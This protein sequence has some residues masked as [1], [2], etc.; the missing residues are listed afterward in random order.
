MVPD[1]IT[2]EESLRQALNLQ[3][4]Y[5]WLSAA[6]VY[7]RVLK[8][9]PAEAPLTRAD[10]LEKQAY[11]LHKAAMQADTLDAFRDLNKKSAEFYQKTKEAAGVPGSPVGQ[12]TGIR[13][14][15]MMAMI[16][17]W[18]AETASDKKLHVDDAWKLA[19]EALDA[20]ESV[21]AR[22]Q[23]AWTFNS[24]ALS[25]A[26]SYNY[27]DTA[28]VREGRLREALNYAEKAI[29]HLAD[30]SDPVGLARAHAKTTCI[31]QGIQKDFTEFSQKDSV[32][33]ES[34]NHW[35]KA[36]DASE[37][38]ALSE[39]I[40][41]VILQGWPSACSTDER[42]SIYLKAK[43]LA[44]R[45]GDRFL[46][47]LV[48]DGLAQRKF[49]SSVSAEDRSAK[50]SI[51]KEGFEAAELSRENLAKV[52][53]VSPNVSVVWSSVPAAGYYFALSYDEK[54]RKKRRSLLEEGYPHCVEQ[55]RLAE[56]SGYPEVQ[57]A[58]EYMLGGILKGLAETEAD[59]SKK[60]SHLNKALEHL[61]K[62]IADDRSL[63]PNQFYLQGV[64]M[65][66]LADAQH[67]LARVVTDLEPKAS[68]LSEAIQNSHASIALCEK[69][70]AATQD[71][72]PNVIGVLAHDYHTLGE[73]HLELHRMK[74]TVS[75]LEAAAD[76]FDKAVA[77][78]MKSDLPS[79]SAESNWAAAQVYETLGGYQNA[80][81]RF[82]RAAA[83]YERAGALM[84]KLADFYAE[85]A[86][87]MRAWSAIER[88]KYHHIRQE[89]ELAKRC[90]REAAELH[91]STQRWG[92]LATNY[93]AWAEVENAEDLSRNALTAEAIQAFG[94]AAKLFAESKR[95][96][97]GQLSKVPDMDE[98]QTVR[99]LEKAADLR[100]IYCEARVC[101]EEA[102]QLGKQGRAAE[103]AEKYGCA[104]DMLAKA[105]EGLEVEQD[106]KEISAI[107]ALAKAWRV[108][109]Q[110]EA[111]SS[112]ALY[113]EASGLFEEA[114]EVSLA[115]KGKL[116]ALGHSRLCK[117]MELG[118]RFSDTG[119]LAL[120]VLV[121]QNL[122]SA[123]SYYTKAGSNSAA[124]LVKANKL[125]F[126]GFVHITKAGGETDHETKTRL[127]V[128]AEK[129][130]VAS[131]SSLEKAGEPAKADQARALL[132]KVSEEKELAISLGEVLLTPDV[133][134][135]SVAFSSPVMSFE[136]A[137]GMQTLEHANIQA[138]VRA[139]KQKVKVGEEFEIEIE[140]VNAG[141][142]QAEVSAVEGLLQPGLEIV[143]KPE[144]CRVEESELVLR[145]KRINPLATEDMAVVVKAHAK[146]T[147]V[148]SP[149]VR[150]LDESGAT[151]SSDANQ[152]SVTV[153]ELGI[154]G[155]L[156][157]P[158]KR[159]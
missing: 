81:E 126:E 136:K 55:L 27:A 39:A 135:S 128:M 38:G 89:P 73:W 78:S 90:F 34:W 66:L 24:L 95:S 16:R 151:R 42:L 3:G 9:T 82:S 157:G 35:L 149:K 103:S 48:L 18:I 134:T 77:S 17:Y 1:E 150:Y 13:C 159:K 26:I 76:A 138:K 137:T 2:A 41:A 153:T 155:W 120:H 21:G 75:D 45:A 142:Y 56:E 6:D 11:A 141:R 114:K 119:D 83:G 31:L 43:A 32:D 44:E 148:L 105:L 46:S 127:Y 57:S 5:K 146:G 65:K 8:E 106:R 40:F 29:R 140:L 14:D 68:L 154:G 109:A 104:V 132:R 133:L 107:L 118:T 50:G 30:G 100:M 122:E 152:V 53:Y 94:N 12:A 144:K 108:M 111:E 158:E 49:A 52:S 37:E 54:D 88:G 117:A 19:K 33:L 58:A 63:H 60:T 98:T 71:T 20:F 72:N 4:E 96:L 69:E 124:E 113:A 25:A 97:H 116:L 115:E 123:A 80:S 86:T 62:A 87:Y 143:R 59:I 28:E 156:R 129:L 64:D 74:G 7:A 36:R 121:N 131:V 147:F 47:G 112:P 23:F 51:V 84:P 110:A 102:R 15:A 99:R 93:S 85:H 130:L 22:A 101:L 61:G 139:S 125:M 10:L 79:K 70:I 67:E 145:G 92:Y 91:G